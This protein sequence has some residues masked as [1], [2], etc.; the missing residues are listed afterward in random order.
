MDLL[1][2]DAILSKKHLKTQVVFVEDWQGHVNVRELTADERDE[3]ES[4]LSA[5]EGTS[6]EERRE[7]LKNLRGR[8]AARGLADETGLRMFSDE[9]SERLGSLSA[10]ALDTI[11]DTVLN[12]SGMTKAERERL[13]KNS[14]PQTGEGGSTTA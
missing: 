9:D 8:V 5:P 6:I 1:S 3:V 7:S 2:R 12:L 13:R 4:W 14:R 10:A 11:F